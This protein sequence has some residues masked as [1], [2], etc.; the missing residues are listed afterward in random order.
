MDMN[1]LF[2]KA[3]MTLFLSAACLWAYA[4]QTVTGVVVDESGEPLI[5]VRVQVKVTTKGTRNEV[6]GTFNEKNVK[7][8]KV[9]TQ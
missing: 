7:K 5:G 2:R 9:M 1:S 6:D 3:M 8:S 4:Q